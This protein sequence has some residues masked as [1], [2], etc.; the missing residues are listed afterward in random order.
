MTE[1]RT[2]T[3]LAKMD[4]VIGN[5]QSLEGLTLKKHL[6][7]VIFHTKKSSSK[8]DIQPVIKC[9]LMLNVGIT[10][11]NLLTY[12]H[13]LTKAKLDATS[14]RRVSALAYYYF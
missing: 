1:G 10:D 11:N 8:L 2:S 14:Q 5:L 7:A 9:N 13:V 6:G 4:G 3:T 12:I